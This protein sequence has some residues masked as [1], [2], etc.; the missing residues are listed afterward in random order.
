MLVV[1]YPASQTIQE[2]RPCEG[3][4]PII[5]K[6][7]ALTQGGGVTSITYTPDKQKHSSKRV[8]I[9]SFVYHVIIKLTTRCTEE[10]TSLETK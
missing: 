4:S 5:K 9:N 3:H 10:E 8:A 2:K 1:T 7:L 6:C